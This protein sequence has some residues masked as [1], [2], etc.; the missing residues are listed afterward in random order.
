M[1]MEDGRQDDGYDVRDEPVVYRLGCSVGKLMKTGTET[2]QALAP[3]VS[4][5][6]PDHGRSHL[7]CRPFPS[8][9]WCEP[10][11]LYYRE[12]AVP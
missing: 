4:F 10:C 9:V 1:A 12:V 8:L 5:P 6:I 7:P 2:A 3:K 11:G